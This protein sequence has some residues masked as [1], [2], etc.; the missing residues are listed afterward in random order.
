MTTKQAKK[1]G[2]DA[3]KWARANL[4]PSDLALWASEQLAKA[5]AAQRR[6]PSAESDVVCYFAAAMAAS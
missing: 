5:E 1:R 2:I 4:S 3:A 6:G